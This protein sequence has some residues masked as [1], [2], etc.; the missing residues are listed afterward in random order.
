MKK[1]FQQ[2]NISLKK[3]YS[4]NFLKDT[5][6]IDSMLRELDLTPE[7]SVF[8]IGGGAGVLTKAILHQQLKQLWVFEI[9][10]EWAQELRK[11]KDTRLTVFEDNFLDFDFEKFEPDK[12][13]T[14]IANLPY[15][16]TFPILHLLQRHRHLL[17]AGVI[18]VQEEVAQKILKRSGRNYG[19]ISLF[20]Q[21]YFDWKL[22]DKVPPEAFYPKPKIFSRLLYL[23]PKKDVPNIEH[24]ED[25]WRFIK[26]CFKQPR[27]TLRNNLAQTHYDISVI[28][29]ET[30]S[31]RAQQLSMDDLLMIWRQ[32]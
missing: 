15:Q 22:L 31:L 17:S 12:P 7:T 8:E 10:P 19:F 6:Y 3:K 23:K 11:I 25:F 21:W 16:I 1:I 29:P 5:S 4:Q 27:R 32:L 18:M 20:F 28:V 26:V 24:E 30:L 13:W 9:D 2:S 14:L